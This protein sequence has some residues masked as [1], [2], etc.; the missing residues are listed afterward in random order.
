MLFQLEQ[1][2]PSTQHKIR[3]MPF[4]L[5]PQIHWLRLAERIRLEEHKTLVPYRGDHL[6]SRWEAGR[7][8]VM[9]SRDQIVSYVSLEPLSVPGPWDM[10]NHLP[11]LFE[12]RTG[13][14]DPRYRR[15]GISLFLRHQLI[16]ARFGDSLLF[17][18]CKGVAASPVL[19]KMGWTT[20]PWCEFPYVSSL[21]GW[22]SEDGFYKSGFGQTDSHL[23]PR[24]SPHRVFDQQMRECWEGQIHLWCSRS[25]AAAQV[26]EH[27]KQSI[28]TIDLWRGC[29]ERSD[30]VRTA[31]RDRKLNG[32]STAK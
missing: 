5:I 19:S 26:E 12:L 11:C 1:P 22:F 28:E 15:Q 2:N 18:F 23:A 17:A 3:A 31:S 16:N 10:P 30:R 25:E 9:V 20:I 7:A 21:I 24:N 29:I 14:T 32:E 6:R 4:A 8:A 27:F 13:W